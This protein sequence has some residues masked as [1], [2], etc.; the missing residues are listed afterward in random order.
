MN[1]SLDYFPGILI[2][3]TKLE[4]RRPSL[5]DA[6]VIRVL[7]REVAPEA[8]ILTNSLHGVSEMMLAR[9]LATID[10]CPF[11]WADEPKAH[12][13]LYHA[14]LLREYLKANHRTIVLTTHIR[15]L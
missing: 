12:W 11:I 7:P 6:N 3:Y 5:V 8:M 10:V 4:Y 13:K 1:L 15:Y 9:S 14:C 2:E